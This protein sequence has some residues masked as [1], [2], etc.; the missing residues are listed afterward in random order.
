MESKWMQ[1]DVDAKQIDV[2]AKASGNGWKAS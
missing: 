2:D 1:I